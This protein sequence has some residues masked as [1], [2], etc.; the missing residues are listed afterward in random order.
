[1][2][3]NHILVVVAGDAIR[4]E[5]DFH[6][7]GFVIVDEV[8]DT[9]FIGTRMAAVAVD[10]GLGVADLALY[11]VVVDAVVAYRTVLQIFMAILAVGCFLEVV[12]VLQSFRSGGMH[13]FGGVA[14]FAAHV[15][16]TK[17]DVTLTAGTKKLV[18]DP[19]A[20]AGSTLVNRVRFG[21]ENVAVYKSF[22]GIFGPAHM[23]TAT[24]GMA[25]GAVPIPAVIYLVP[26]VLAGTFFQIARKCRQG[27]MQRLRYGFCF[28][29]TLTAGFLGIVDRWMR[30]KSLV[31]TLFVIG[32][33]ITAMAIHTGKLAMGRLQKFL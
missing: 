15:V 14:I 11:L 20:V 22:T 32:G 9:L 28:F 21:T 25:G 19:A 8:G 33:V 29:M 4:I 23:T 31:G 12:A 3:E 2:P 1:M 10:I 30:I 18:A 24:T 6:A 26:G 5:T 13:L 7:L 16:F 17:V 27:H